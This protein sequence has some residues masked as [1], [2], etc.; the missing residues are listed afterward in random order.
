MVKVLKEIYRWR[1]F[2]TNSSTIQEHGNLLDMELQSSTVLIKK[3]T[4]TLS[5]L[6]QQDDLIKPRI[7]IVRGHR[8]LMLIKAL[9]EAFCTFGYSVITMYTKSF[10][11]TRKIPST[12][13]K[14]LYQTIPS[15]LNFYNNGNDQVDK[16]YNIIDFNQKCLPYDLLLKDSNCT[17]L[18]LINPLLKSYNLEL[19]SKLSKESNKYPQVITIFS[20]KLNPILKNKKIKEIFVD[21]EAFKTTKHTIIQKAKSTFK[22]YETTLLSLIIRYIKI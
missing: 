7:I 11:K 15:I 2:F 21:S 13:K 4:L 10:I 12:T 6:H 17:K 14:E 16:N 18:I 20:E 22:Y 3:S 9:T 8:K 5:R 19:I 1:F